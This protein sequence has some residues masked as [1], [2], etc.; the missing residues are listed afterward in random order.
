MLVGLLSTYESYPIG[1]RY[2]ASYLENEG[3]DVILARLKPPFKDNL[4]QLWPGRP[5]ALIGLTCYTPGIWDVLDVAKTL[6]ESYPDVKI[7]LGN[8]HATV[9]HQTLLERFPFV[10]F[11]ILGEGEIP[12]KE[13]VEHVEEKRDISDVHNLAYRDTRGIVQITDQ[14]TPHADLDNFYD[15]IDCSESPE[16]YFFSPLGGAGLFR[17]GSFD[18]L[19]EI[20]S[21]RGCYYHCSYCPEHMMS[22]GKW[23][24]HSPER[25]VNMLEQISLTHQTSKFMFWDPLFTF[26][27]ERVITICKKIIK[28]GLKIQWL[29]QTHPNHIDEETVMWVHKAGCMGFTIG[30]DCMDPA[31]AKRHRHITINYENLTKVV[32]LARSLKMSLRLNVIAGWPERPVSDWITTVKLLWRVQ[33]THLAIF[34]LYLSPGST[35][36]QDAVKKDLINQ[37]Y[38]LEKRKSPYY[39]A[40]ESQKNAVY[41]TIR[42]RSEQFLL[43]FIHLITC[44]SI[45]GFCF[46]FIFHLEYP[47]SK[48][49]LVM[50]KINPRINFRRK[51]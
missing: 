26:D 35:L 46:F 50:K 49:L 22:C 42:L 20:I 32:R 51:V 5:P 18:R 24:A 4:L 27:K 28:R 1:L 47:V 10:D 44:R 7:V 39:L 30:A 2:I 37:D 31:L 43:T 41:N 19:F 12:M 15:H 9:F 25:V 17:I 6:K 45:D 38:W 48:L 11:I 21:S 16:L 29:F 3:H 14:L 33:P 36:Y 8:I 13:L 23:R 40:Y 34:S